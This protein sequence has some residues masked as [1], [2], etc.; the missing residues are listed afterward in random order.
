MIDIYT[1]VC[2][3]T[4]LSNRKCAAS[5]L[6]LSLLGALSLNKEN[7]ENPHSLCRIS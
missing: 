7:R 2:S 6:K 1:L 5:T 3:R 4:T